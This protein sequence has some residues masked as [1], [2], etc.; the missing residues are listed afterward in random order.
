MTDRTL[1]GMLAGA[2]LKLAS[3]RHNAHFFRVFSAN[4]GDPDRIVSL[5]DQVLPPRRKWA[6]PGR[7]VRA[8]LQADQLDRRALMNAALNGIKAGAADSPWAEGL[9]QLLGEVRRRVAC[10]GGMPL[11]VPEIRAISKGKGRKRG[12][13]AGEY[14]AVAAFTNLSDRLLI[15]AVSRYLSRALD[16]LF[17]GSSH[18][19]RISSAFSRSAAVKQVHDY[20]VA[21]QGGPIYVAECDIRHFF[22]SVD[23]GVARMAFRRAVR[24]R[25]SQGEQ[26]DPR[27][28][29]IM[30][31]YL[32][33]YDYFTIGKPAA[34]NDLRKHAPTGVLSGLSVEELRALRP[35]GVMG[36]VGIPQGGALSPLLTNLILDAADRVVLGDGSDPD[37]LYVRYC[38]DMI[39]LHKDRAR[40]AEA[41][42]RYIDKVRELLFLVHPPVTI[43]LYD[44]TFFDQKSKH[45]YQ[46]ATPAGREGVAPWTSFLGYQIRH[47]GQIRVKRESL[48]KHK[49]RQKAVV[50][51]AMNLARKPAAALRRTNE[52]ILHRV[53]FRLV[54]AAVGRRPG[55]PVRGSGRSWMDAFHLL[56]RNRYSE[57][58]MRRLDQFRDGLLIK[59]GFV[60]NTVHPGNQEEGVD[61]GKGSNKLYWKRP[62]LGRGLSYCGKLIGDSHNAPPRRHASDSGYGVDY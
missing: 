51:K 62:V 23:H 57:W 49:D 58:Q 27:T 45:P 2:R 53:A 42:Q 3:R 9:Q 5:V 20:V 31:M 6:R 38:D 33:C 39:I 25:E 50:V 32:D 8:S 52:D 56:S 61:K 30:E 43:G 41:L 14:R 11:Q 34:E 22:D 40:C 48:D 7:K 44:K 29:D 13:G 12:P 1:V 36:K 21:G 24:L 54:A 59:L 17:T 4:A 55:I 60:L 35:D 18:A 46:L 10:P 16:S 26:V 47:D 15:G 19:F 28:V 37:L